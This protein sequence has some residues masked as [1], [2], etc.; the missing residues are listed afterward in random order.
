MPAV[1]V[2]QRRMAHYRLPFFELLRSELRDRNVE[3]R[4]AFG[5]DSPAELQ[6]DD[7]GDLT[8]AH[9]LAT[10]YFFDGRLCWQPLG[11]VMNGTAMVVLTP[12][13]RLICNL[14]AQY[15]RR[16]LRIGLWGHGGNFQGD[17]NSLRERFKR[18]TSRRAD[19]WFAYTNLS[20]PLIERC[21]FPHERITVLNN[22]VDTT[23][24]ASM[25][26]AV[27][28]QRLE[29]LRS[30]LGIEGRH[31]GA[32]VGSLYEEK[33]IDF[34]L[35]AAARIHSSFPVFEF[36]IAGAGPKSAV[37]ER[38]C[39]ANPWAKY[40]GMRTGQ[41]KVDLLA[42]AGVMIHPGAVGLS[43]LDSFACGVPL[44]TTDCGLHGPEI[45]YLTNDVNGLLTADT[46]EAYASGVLDLLKDP[47][48][49][50]RLQA[51]CRKSAAEFTVENMAR[52]FADGVVGCLAAPMY[53]GRS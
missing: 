35:D 23:A 21:G 46:L 48:R 5:D 19:W 49:I 3:L 40:L 9:R 2:V 6:R 11:K 16:E 41:D 12:E 10:R 51:G 28:P 29:R 36:L 1:L 45:A 30:E 20:V 33:R 44:A 42:L 50:A 39:A 25:R 52:N 8:W 14:Y 43:V 4:V 24:L 26:R 31:V 38:F 47:S 17:P 37:V 7:A 15:L 13:N 18:V 53:R 34:T 32:F 27:T 22:A